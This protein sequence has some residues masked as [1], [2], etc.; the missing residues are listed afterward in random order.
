LFSFHLKVQVPEDLI[1]SGI[2]DYEAESDAVNTLQIKN[3][4]KNLV[5]PQKSSKCTAITHGS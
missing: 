1:S 2:E 4:S 3:K 5:Y